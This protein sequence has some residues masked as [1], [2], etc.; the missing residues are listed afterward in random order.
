[1]TIPLLEIAIPFTSG[2]TEN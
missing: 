1:L 2:R